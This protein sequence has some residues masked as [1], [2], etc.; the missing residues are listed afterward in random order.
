MSRAKPPPMPPATPDEIELQFYEALQRAMVRM[1]V[2][3]HSGTRLRGMFVRAGLCDVEQLV[4]SFDF[5][6]SEFMQMF[7]VRERLAAAETAGE[8][9]AQDGEYFLAAIEERDRAGTF[10]GSAIGYTVAGTKP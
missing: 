7:F 1:I 3:P 6:H 2:N 9:T 8:I 4:K 10:Y 5:N